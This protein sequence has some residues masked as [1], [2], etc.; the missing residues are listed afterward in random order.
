MYDEWRRYQHG[1]GRQHTLSRGQGTESRRRKRKV[2][3]TR[4]LSVVFLEP[5]KVL[6]QKSAF[7]IRIAFTSTKYNHLC[8]LIKLENTL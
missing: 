1:N 6:D 7:M 2:D 4:F 8:N 3:L 5:T